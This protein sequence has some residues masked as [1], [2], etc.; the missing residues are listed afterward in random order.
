MTDQ[1][2]E[3]YMLMIALSL[4]TKEL[5]D[6]KETM[7]KDDLIGTD[8]L[9]TLSVDP[10][11]K[12]SASL[13]KTLEGWL[14]FEETQTAP[15]PTPQSTPST[16]PISLEKSLPKEV[17]IDPI[18]TAQVAISSVGVVHTQEQPATSDAPQ[19]PQ[20][21]T[22]LSLLSKST[23]AL[24]LSMSLEEMCGD[25]SEDQGAEDDL[26]LS[27][28]RGRKRKFESDSQEKEK[29]KKKI[30][31]KMIKLQQEVKE[32]KKGLGTWKK[33]SR[34]VVG[35]PQ[36]KVKDSPSWKWCSQTT[37]RTILR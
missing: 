23:D 3:D 32:R 13:D 37:R 17:A 36:N 8:K 30:R 28:S 10:G 12:D 4:S 9:E 26:S 27:S 31:A 24:S 19:V 11:M 18:I 14:Q 15:V 33:A 2:Y 5:E 35:K 21:P 16:S 29:R 34:K 20:L 7:H 1:E 6:Q 25:S 22:A